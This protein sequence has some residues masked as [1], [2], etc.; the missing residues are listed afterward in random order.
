VP[1]TLADAD[2]VIVDVGTGFYV[3]KV[4]CGIATHRQGADVCRVRK[5]LRSFMRGR[6]R[7]WEII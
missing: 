6:W 4:G 2:N 7:S 1:G 5:M 3:E